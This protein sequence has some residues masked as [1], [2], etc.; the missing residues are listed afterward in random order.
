MS[1]ADFRD[2]MFANPVRFWGEANPAFFQGTLIEKAVEA[3]PA[4][5]SGRMTA[6]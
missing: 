6:D 1:E 4:S 2:F 3:L 5:T